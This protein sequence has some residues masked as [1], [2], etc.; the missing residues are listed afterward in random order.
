[1]F[2]ITLPPLDSRFKSAGY[3]MPPYYLDVGN[4]SL[5]QASLKGFA[6]YFNTD[7]FCVIY[8]EADVDEQTILHWTSEIGLPKSNCRTVPLPEPT[9]GQADMVRFGIEATSCENDPREEAIIFTPDVIYR[10]FKK[11]V[12]GPSDYLDVTTVP[13][14]NRWYIEPDPERPNHVK[15]IIEDTNVSDLSCLGLYGFRSTE[16]FMEYYRTV[17]GA[18]HGQGYHRV[19]PIYQRMI[20]DGSPVL[21]RELPKTNVELVDTPERYESYSA[22]HALQPSNFAWR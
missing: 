9:P 2:Y 8:P 18:E 5:F 14:S 12:G 7:L 21:Y 13:E 19:A 3:A 10:Q 16:K 22:N 1:M 4:L 17:Y 11:P 15:R 20:D 6:N